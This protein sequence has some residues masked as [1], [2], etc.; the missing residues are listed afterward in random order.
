MVKWFS[1]VLIISLMAISYAE[2]KILFI[3]NSYTAGIRGEVKGI[4][5][6]DSPATVV[7]FICPGGKTILFHYSQEGTIKKVKEGNWNFIVLQDQS[8]TPALSS[9]KKGFHE[10]VDSFD[11]LFKSMGEKR[12]KLFLYMTWGRRDGDKANKTEFPDYQTMQNKLTESYLEAGKRVKAEVVPVGLGFQEFN[13]T[14]LEFFK[15]LYVGDGSHPSKQ[16]AYLAALLFYCK[17]KNAK[18]DE[19]KYKPQLDE[20]DAQKIRAV[21]KKLLEQK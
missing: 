13:K 20:A 4:F 5:A 18:V 1:V 9:T 15:K 10:G 14:D 7:E 3:G 2:E 17:M 19:L 6:S 21:A 12:P 16:G 11:K 8:Q